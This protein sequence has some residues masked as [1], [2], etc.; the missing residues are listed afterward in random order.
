VEKCTDTNGYCVCVCLPHSHEL[1]SHLFIRNNAGQSIKQ[2]WNYKAHFF[3]EIHLSLMLASIIKL[4]GFLMPGAKH[5]KISTTTFTIYTASVSVFAD[6]GCGGNMFFNFNFLISV[7][8]FTAADKLCTNQCHEPKFG[9]NHS[10]RLP[11]I[12][13]FNQLGL[14]QAIKAFFIFIIEQTLALKIINLEG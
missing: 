9:E 7:Y 5:A 11:R 13:F 6:G 3:E 2:T 4:Y 14:I 12:L 1:F 8:I 10:A